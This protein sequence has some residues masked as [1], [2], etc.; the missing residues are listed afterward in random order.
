VGAVVLLIVVFMLVRNSKT[1]TTKSSRECDYDEEMSSE[2]WQE[3]RPCARAPRP[4]SRASTPPAVTP[5]GTPTVMAE[6]VRNSSG[7][8]VQ[9]IVQT[10]SSKMS[11]G[12]SEDGLLVHVVM[13]ECV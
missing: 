4:S 3:V 8:I 11:I 6:H 9:N 5:R 7:N 10:G 2:Q 13:A 1:K 12:A